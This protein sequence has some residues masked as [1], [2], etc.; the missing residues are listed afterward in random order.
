MVRDAGKLYFMVEGRLPTELWVKAHVKRCSVAGVPMIV[1][2]RGDP[3]SGIV[4]LKLNQ[5]EAGC[6]VMS[7]MRDLEGKLGWLEALDGALVPEAQ[8]DAYIARQ[9][10]R[11]PDLWV[12]EI[13]D[14]EGRHWV[15]G[16]VI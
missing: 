9:A 5:L 1:A 8:A 7:Q 13:E 2:R 10:E 15:D 4:I 16:D 3:H 6:R 12:I 11:D 14:R